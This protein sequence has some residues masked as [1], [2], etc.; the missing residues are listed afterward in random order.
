MAT[1]RIRKSKSRTPADGQSRSVWGNQGRIAAR[2][3]R[4]S[5]KLR[6]IFDRLSK[7]YGPQHWWPAETPTEVAIGAILTQNTAWR[8][9]ER[10]IANLRA[11]D[12]LNWKALR[13]ISEPA[14]AKLIRPSG[15]FRV[16]ASRL[17]AFV[18]ELWESH[19]G[20]LEAM[21]DG[22]VELVRKRLLEIHGIGP[23][24]A[25][26]I[27]L[28]S[29]QRPSFVVDAYTRRVLRRHFLIDGEPSYDTVRQ[30]FHRSL[31]ADARLFNEFHALLVTVG[32]QHCRS[33]AMCEGC[34]LEE[35]RHDE[36]I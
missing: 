4:A 31:P 2:Y 6:D 18:T 1:R 13:D 27:L 9:V 19:Q 11:A 22:E 25:D 26:A 28:Y 35:L 32:K 36:R 20:S 23:E 30:L 3:L 7:A 24:T 15:T 10:A 33:R 21:L 16:K 34:P 12:C 8:N 17:K 5:R 14:L 29:G